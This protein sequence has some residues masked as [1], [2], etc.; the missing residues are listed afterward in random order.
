M[1]LC[2]IDHEKAFDRVKHEDLIEIL[3]GTGVDGKDLRMVY[4]LYW[5]Q[6]AAVKVGTD[7]CN[8]LEIRRVVRQGCVLSPDLFS[9]Y[10]DMIM[11]SVEG[12]KGFVIKIC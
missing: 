5:N 2:F 6:R 4:N 10:S 7:Q 8:W 12:K 1:Y 11:R 3:K 9:L